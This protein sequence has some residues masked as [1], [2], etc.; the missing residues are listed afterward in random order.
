MSSTPPTSSASASTP[1][2]AGPPP[3]LSSIG[4]SLVPLT[5]PLSTS[6]NSQPLCG[7][8]LDDKYILIG[9]FISCISAHAGIKILTRP[10][11]TTGGLDF[12]PIPLPGSLP[13]RTHG[14]KRRETRKPIPL[15]KRTRFKE[16]AVLSERSNILLAIAGRND[17]IRVYALDGIR[18]MIE[19][20]MAEIDLRDGYPI[21]PDPKLLATPA[22]PNGKGKARAEAPLPPR[23]ST[24]PALSTFP[25]PASSQASGAP[26]S[27]FP[28]TSP[29]PDY[30]VDAPAPVRR[31]PPPL[32]TAS[33]GNYGQFPLPS[34]VRPPPSPIRA[35]TRISAGPGNLV[36]AIPT[37]PRPSAS[38]RAAAIPPSPRT[39]RGQKSR[40]FV[41]GRKG[42]TAVITKRK[43]RSDLSGDT[44]SASAAS[45]RSSIHSTEGRSSRRGSES[46]AYPVPDAAYRRHGSLGPTLAVPL[47]APSVDADDIEDGGDEA[48]VARRYPATPRSSARRQSTSSTGDSG[49]TTDP[50]NSPVLGRTPR[51]EPRAPA[52]TLAKTSGSTSLDLADFFRTTGPDAP[53]GSVSPTVPFTAR[54]SRSAS[55][56]SVWTQE[57]QNA[58]RVRHLPRAPTVASR[59]ESG[60]SSTL[61]LADFIR[62]GFPEPEAQNGQPA[63]QPPKR[64][65]RDASPSNSPTLRSN[66]GPDDASSFHYDHYTSTTHLLGEETPQVDS[67]SRSPSPVQTRSQLLPRPATMPRPGAH[68]RS[69][70][71][72][73][74]DTIRNTGP[75]DWDERRIAPARTELRSNGAKGKAVARPATAQGSYYPRDGAENT[76][77]PLQRSV[78]ARARLSPRPATTGRL[79]DGADAGDE[80]EELENGESV[81]RRRGSGMSFADVIRDGPPPGFGSPPLLPPLP[82]SASAPG[83]LNAPPS[84]NNRASKRWTM[85]GMGQKFLSRPS[86]EGSPTL[87]SSGSRRGSAETRRSSL[88]CD[89]NAEP[90]TSAVESVPVVAPAAPQPHRAS[91]PLPPHDFKRPATA[92]AQDTP[93]LPASSQLPPEAHPANV[94]YSR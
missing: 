37:N 33:M 9:T 43:S 71:L 77:G 86:T 54:S 19:K 48:E 23:P 29:P 32:T 51:M 59:D 22:P 4:L 10:T 69:S 21:I 46:A 82:S 80:Q 76:G 78:S 2:T 35:S 34:P 20:K 75:D 74:A 60:R 24:A 81:P 83:M 87:P 90:S 68:E 56:G 67:R 41:T 91:T 50:S 53:T 89:P 17:H 7:A 30:A 93:T 58:G 13:M 12:L 16:I 36:R 11:G 5:Q 70:I 64:T 49:W 66:L 40:E 84:P 57:T 73:L 39:L 14:K 18:A 94:R 88:Q 45:R 1:P 61:D 79:V 8:L 63:L 65:R 52:T 72:E 42:S 28:M 6:R 27:L 44:T 55:N 38:S 31:R 85:S 3:T 15:I 26:P 47:A 62:N 25:P 92:P